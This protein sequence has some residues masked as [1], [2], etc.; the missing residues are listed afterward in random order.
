MIYAACPKCNSNDKVTKI[1]ALAKSEN[2]PRIN[3]KFP[4]RPS[5]EFVRQGFVSKEFD[6]SE[7]FNYSKFLPTKSMDTINMPDFT[8][9]VF[10]LLIIFGCVAWNTDFKT[11][12]LF[13]TLAGAFIIIL[14]LTVFLYNEAVGKYNRRQY[15]IISKKGE[16]ALEKHKLSRE[17]ERTLFERSERERRDAFEK[18][19]LEREKSFKQQAQIEMWRYEKAVE[20]WNKTYYCERDDIVFIPDTNEYERS[21][22]LQAFLYR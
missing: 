4:V 17:K 16:Q 14:P 21:D 11:S 1:S 9:G 19:E 3:L 20:R 15:E 10:W 18:A 13:F 7:G 12:N 22:K 5:M 8:G 2:R 6:L